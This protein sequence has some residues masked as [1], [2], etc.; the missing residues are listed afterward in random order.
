MQGDITS[1]KAFTQLEPNSHNA[2]SIVWEVAKMSDATADGFSFAVE[3]SDDLNG[4]K[5]A[6]E[7]G[8]PITTLEDSPSVLR[9]SLSKDKSSGFASFGVVIPPEAAAAEVK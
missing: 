6:N 5:A 1:P 2:S 3:G 7:V 4:W 9:V 8:S